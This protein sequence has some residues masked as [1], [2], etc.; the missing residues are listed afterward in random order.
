MERRGRLKIRPTFERERERDTC[1]QVVGSSWSLLPP[2]S[3]QCFCCVFTDQ[4]RWSGGREGRDAEEEEEKEDSC[5]RSEER[6]ESAREAE[7]SGWRGKEHSCGERP[8]SKYPIGIFQEN[9]LLDLVIADASMSFLVYFWI[10]I[11]LQ[12]HLED[13]VLLYAARVASRVAVSY[14][15]LH[16]ASRSLPICPLFPAS[17]LSPRKIRDKYGRL[18]ARIDEEEVEM[19]R[20]FG[21]EVVYSFPCP[22]LS[23]SHS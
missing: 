19:R 3:S 5:S 16:P 13:D 23:F 8:G 2:P 1:V 17:I 9:L 12:F 6:G 18:G 21:L 20:L 14:F 15:I 4:R 22:S 7:W 11:R 10:C